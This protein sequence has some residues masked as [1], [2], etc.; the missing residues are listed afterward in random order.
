[1]RSVTTTAALDV[2][3]FVS[4]ALSSCYIR[5]DACDLPLE[6]A[7]VTSSGVCN[8]SGNGARFSNVRQLC[9]KAV[10]AFSCTEQ[11]GELLQMVR[12]TGQTDEG[13]QG[14]QQSAG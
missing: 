11:Y 7:T 1:M 9:S 10:N 5:L 12:P 6:P 13:D 14:Q 8:H 3:T 2:S 4:C